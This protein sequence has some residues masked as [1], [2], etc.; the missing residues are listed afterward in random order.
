MENSKKELEDSVI[1]TNLLKE[2]RYTQ[3]AFALK[4]GI[5][6]PAIYNI[7]NGINK[8]SQGLIDRIIKEF[9]QVHYWYLANGKLPIILENPKLIH[10]Q[11]NLFNTAS[12]KD[13]V[14]YSLE[15]FLT[16]KNI[17]KAI[18][19]QN[20]LTRELLDF[21]KQKKADNQ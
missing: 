14:D 3:R 12:P 9:P 16:L 6:G 4:I 15:S 17:E 21:L 10:N 8:I 11:N 2:L 18:N 5:T 20:E 13:G 19:E 1:I 7:T